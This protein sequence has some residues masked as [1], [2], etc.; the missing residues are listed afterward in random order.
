MWSGVIV[1][2]QVENLA[3]RGYVNAPMDGMFLRAPYLHN[4]SVLTLAELINLKKRRDVFYRGHN[5]YDPIDVGY[6][7]P[8]DLG[9]PGSRMDKAHQKLDGR[10]LARPIGS[11]QGGDPR[12]RDR[13]IKPVK[14]NSAAW[15]E[16]KVS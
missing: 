4:A 11:D 8:E 9:S 3:I 7:S 5:G 13:R 12:R 10:C 1:T 14:H 15:P 2:S 6:R 16:G